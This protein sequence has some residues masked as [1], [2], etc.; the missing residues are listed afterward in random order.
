MSKEEISKIKTILQPWAEFVR[1]G[2]CDWGV[3]SERQMRVIDEEGG[4]EVKED[5][6]WKE[7]EERGVIEILQEWA[8]T[9]DTF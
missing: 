6:R 5:I 2:K 3:E 8:R 7:I 9:G 4:F 1:T